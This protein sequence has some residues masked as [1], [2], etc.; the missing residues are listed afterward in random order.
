MCQ[1]QI[2]GDGVGRTAGRII[3][4]VRLFT[5][6][7]LIS[8]PSIQSIFGVIHGLQRPA[9]LTRRGTR[10]RS[11][12]HLGGKRKA[13]SVQNGWSA[14]LLSPDD[15]KD[16]CGRPARGCRRDRPS[17]HFSNLLP[18][19]AALP[20]QWPVRAKVR[21]WTLHAFMGHACIFVYMRRIFLSTHGMSWKFW[22]RRQAADFLTLMLLLPALSLFSLPQTGSLLTNPG[23]PKQ[24]PP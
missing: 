22:N 7:L 11:E 21:V 3:C 9:M 4:I 8:R 13:R 14:Y 5:H 18:P 10:L 24:S 23:I 17:L 16:T 6:V 2:G 19:F 12:T 1:I 20:R 15:G